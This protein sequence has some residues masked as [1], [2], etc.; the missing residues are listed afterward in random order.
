MYSRNL[1]LNIKSAAAKRKTECVTSCAAQRRAF[2]LVEL[3]IIVAILGILAAIVTPEFSGHIQKAKESAAKENLRI[4][5]E[6]VDRYAARNNAAA[7]GYPNNDE[8]I[9]PSWMFANINS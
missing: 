9:V 1:K 4:F 6:A 5:R 2:S 7:P 3:L 8:H